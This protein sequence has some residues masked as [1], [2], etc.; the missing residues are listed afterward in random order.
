MVK[1]NDFQQIFKV[2]NKIDMNQSTDGLR[3]WRL[4]EVAAAEVGD[5]SEVDEVF[6]HMKSTIYNEVFRKLCPNL[7]TMRTILR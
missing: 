3:R 4:H 5:K 7:T 2:E 6:G 1:C